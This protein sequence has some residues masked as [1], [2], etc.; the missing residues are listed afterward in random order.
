MTRQLWCRI[1][2]YVRAMVN[3][4]LP[5]DDTFLQLTHDVQQ[6]VAEVRLQTTV[7]SCSDA[8]FLHELGDDWTGCPVVD[9]NYLKTNP[10]WCVCPSYKW[11]KRKLCVLVVFYFF[12]YRFC[13]CFLLQ[14]LPTKALRIYLFL[15]S[16]SFA[17][18]YCQLHLA[19][20]S[21][22]CLMW[23]NPV[24]HVGRP[25]VSCG[26]TQCLMWVKPV[27]H[28]GR[29]LWYM[30]Y[31]RRFKPWR[32]KLAVR[33]SIARL[34]LPTSMHKSWREFSHLNHH[35]GQL[36]TT[37]ISDNSRIPSHNTQL[38]ITSTCSGPHPCPYGWTHPQRRTSLQRRTVTEMWR[39]RFGW[40]QSFP[41]PR[42]VGTRPG[43]A[44]PGCSM[45]SAVLGE[46]RHVTRR[47]RFS[48]FNSRDLNN[49]LFNRHLVGR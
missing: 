24:S 26:S 22:Q 25:S 31:S 12:I 27:P 8:E 44:G 30:S 4:I 18:I 45:T 19:G 34:T 28:V 29:P 43:R 49:I 16:L 13:L 47:V 15:S 21:T 41:S 7:I 35:T 23:V 38:S 11:V 10:P 36:Q 40:G 39:F 3:G 48:S 32:F 2:T 1:S 42:A 37:I 20:G 14:W 46:M 9:V 17:I 33:V 6:S 5:Y